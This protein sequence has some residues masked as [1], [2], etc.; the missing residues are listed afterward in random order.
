MGKVYQALGGDAGEALETERARNHLLKFIGQITIPWHRWGNKLHRDYLNAERGYREYGRENRPIV[1][2]SW[3]DEFFD[4]FGFPPYKFREAQE[5]MKEYK[6]EK[7][8]NM[9]RKHTALYDAVEA[10]EE[11]NFTKAHAIMREAKEK[12]NITISPTEIQHA[13][14]KKKDDVWIQTKT[15]A[16]KAIR[17]K[18]EFQ[19]KM[20]AAREK[21]TPNI[22]KA[23]G[24]KPM[25]SSLSQAIQGTETPAA[26]PEIFIEE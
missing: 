18:P 22:A 23:Y 12:Y 25:W 2:T 21:F 6:D 7:F 24:T 16:P 17:E 1:E 19:Q 11:K 20:E 9:V 15:S 4:L 5:L 3:V 14:D 13:I 8:R 26:I 10:M